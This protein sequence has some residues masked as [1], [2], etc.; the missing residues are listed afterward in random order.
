M[1]FLE[2]YIRYKKQT[3]LRGRFGQVWT[4][5]LSSIRGRC[6]IHSAKVR[7]DKLCISKIQKNEEIFEIQGRSD[8]FQENNEEFKDKEFAL[9]KFSFREYP[10]KIWHR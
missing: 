10:S 1:D 2:V 5:S 4:R 8:E 9:R 6:F 7:V 3:N